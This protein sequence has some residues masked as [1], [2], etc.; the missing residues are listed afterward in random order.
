MSSLNKSA[1]TKSSGKVTNS[2]RIT[3]INTV[4]NVI[5]VTKSYGDVIFDSTKSLYINNNAFTIDSTSINKIRTPKITSNNSFS[6]F[7]DGQ[8]VTSTQYKVILKVRQLSAVSIP[9][10]IA[11]KEL[12]ATE[13]LGCDGDGGNFVDVSLELSQIKSRLDT[14]ENKVIGIA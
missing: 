10:N 14:L 4:D 11:A 3:N 6:I 5:E 8:K 13:L 9:T 2:G 12:K 7:N 1:N